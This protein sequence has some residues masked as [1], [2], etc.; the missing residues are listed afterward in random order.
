MTIE[1]HDAD[2]IQKLQAIAQSE[3]RPVEA[4]LKSMIHYYPHV[5]APAVN[6]APQ[7]PVDDDYNERQDPDVRY[8][9]LRAYKEA[10]EYWRAEGNMARANMTDMEM[11]EQF[12]AFDEDGI[13]RLKHELPSESPPPVGSLA[14]ALKIIQ[15]MGGVKGG[16]LIDPEKIDD[17]LRE[18]FADYLIQRMNRGIDE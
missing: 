2:L 8:I 1:I 18:E 12:G 7:T 10:R 17:I 3:N 16:E 4:V 6:D 5:T 13:P 9:Y 15:E 14:Y 11:D